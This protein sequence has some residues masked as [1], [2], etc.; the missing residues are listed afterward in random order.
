MKKSDAELFAL[1]PETTFPESSRIDMIG[2]N[3][4]DGLHYKP[5]SYALQ[6]KFSYG[7]DF[8]GFDDDDGLRETFKTKTKAKK[9]LDEVLEFT[10]DPP[11]EWRI[12]P[13]N[14]YE[15]ETFARF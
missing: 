4:N 8:V 9:E 3:G 13:Y 5:N 12:V 1:A 15:D 14:P 7:W 11:E 6:T 2:Q 10:Q